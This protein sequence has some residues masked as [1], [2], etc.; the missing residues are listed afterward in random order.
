MIN[1][2]VVAGGVISEPSAQALQVSGAKL[3]IEEGK[4]M[5]ITPPAGRASSREK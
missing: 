5:F 1:P 4:T 2:L 3:L